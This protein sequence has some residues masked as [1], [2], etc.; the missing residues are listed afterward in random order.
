MIPVSRG[1]GDCIPSEPPH[2]GG[3]GVPGLGPGTRFFRPRGGDDARALPALG[4]HPPFSF[5]CLA[6]EKRIRRARWK[7]KENAFGGCG[8]LMLRLKGSQQICCVDAGTFFSSRASR[9]VGHGPWRC[10]STASGRPVHPDLNYRNLP[11]RLVWGGW[12]L[13]GPVHMSDRPA[14]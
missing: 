4:M 14:S 9:L 2:G 10:A 6:R 1:M 11:G 5:L 7:R 12:G 13:A 3:T 8:S